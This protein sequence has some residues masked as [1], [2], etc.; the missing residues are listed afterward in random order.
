MLDSLAFCNCDK[1]AN[2]DFLCGVG[3]F[4]DVN[5]VQLAVQVRYV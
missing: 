2:N 1:S 4:D 5:A 3:C